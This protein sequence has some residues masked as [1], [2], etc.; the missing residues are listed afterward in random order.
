VHAVG[1]LCGQRQRPGPLHAEHDGHRR[2]RRRLQR[3]VVDRE[4]LAGEGHALAGEEA[5]HEG[6]ALAQ[7]AQR[8]LERDV[9]LLVDPAAV[10]AAQAE[11]DPARRQTGQ[12]GRLHR[13][14]GRVPRVRVDDA[15][16]DRDPLGRRRRRAGQREGARLEVV[17]DDPQAPEARALGATG[18]RDGRAR[19]AVAQE[20]DAE[21]SAPARVHRHPAAS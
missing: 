10:A 21:A 16:A 20:R 12:G 6:G 8:R 18:P 5:A 17:L 3:H 9:H 2:D 15:E 4:A 19:Q 7:A 13:D 14:Q 11:H 1:N